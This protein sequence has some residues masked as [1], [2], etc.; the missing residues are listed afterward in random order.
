MNDATQPIPGPRY[1]PKT[2][3]TAIRILRMLDKH[4]A[5]LS[6]QSL[7]H[8]CGITLA[9]AYRHTDSLMHTGLIYKDDNKFIIDPRAR[10]L[11]NAA[12][13]HGIDVVLKG[14][15]QD[16]G[17]DIALATLHDGQLVLTHLHQ[18]LK[19]ESLLAA[20]PSQAVHATAAGKALLAALPKTER[21]RLLAQNGMP[22]YTAKTATT[23]EALEERLRPDENGI[24]SAEGEFCEI[25]GC[26]AVLADTGR[27]Y[28]DCIAVTT[29]VR[30]VDLPHTRGQLT[31]QL[32]RTVVLLKPVLGPLL[33]PPA[34]TIT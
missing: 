25:G 4:E 1:G 30:V 11:T 9:A 14:F 18:S 5:G 17:R 29:S 20:V 8:R 10:L 16:S 24:W 15:V 22:R 7:A 12:D 27:V 23:P 2:P 6:A 26:L 3:L 34:E 21:R 32:H 28:A 19:S 13:H 33:P 31:A